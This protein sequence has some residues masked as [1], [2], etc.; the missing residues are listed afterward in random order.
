MSS[1]LETHRCKPAKLQRCMNYLP[2]MLHC[3]GSLCMLHDL[4]TNLI[5]FSHV[6]T[7]LVCATLSTVLIQRKLAMQSWTDF[8]AC[9]RYRIIW[10]C[11]NLSNVSH[12]C[13]IQSPIKSIKQWRSVIPGKTPKLASLANPID[14]EEA[15][16]V[17]RKTS[18]RHNT[19]NLAGCRCTPHRSGKFSSSVLNYH[20]QI[21]TCCCPQA[22]C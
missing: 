19:I 13:S 14:A 18:G 11:S 10:L 15:S 2:L 4:G 16:L 1:L 5:A 17:D 7:V 22:R 12:T 9:I 21:L 8:P 6:G 20:M 3:C